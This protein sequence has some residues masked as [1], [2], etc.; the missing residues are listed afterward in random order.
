MYSIS[1]HWRMREK[2]EGSGWEGEM[3]KKGRKIVR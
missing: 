3:K 1:E 2:V